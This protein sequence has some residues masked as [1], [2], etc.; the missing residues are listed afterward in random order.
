MVI[1]NG[2]LQ[3]D[4]RVYPAKRTQWYWGSLSAAFLE[5]PASN[6]QVLL[7]DFIRPFQLLARSLEN[8]LPFGYDIN[9]SG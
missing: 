9:S 3:E 7:P 6:L 4:E 1:A 5:F 8:N 2:S